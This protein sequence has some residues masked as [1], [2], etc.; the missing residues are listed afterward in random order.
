MVVVSNVDI[1]LQ[2]RGLIFY[3]QVSR[4]FINAC[5]V[6]TRT[7][8]ATYFFHKSRKS[9]QKFY[10]SKSPLLNQINFLL[11]RAQYSSDPIEIH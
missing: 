6:S 1:I 5:L 4:H 7:I 3:G 8:R 2:L 9:T 10:T 11:G